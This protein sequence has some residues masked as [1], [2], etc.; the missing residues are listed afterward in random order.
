MNGKLTNDEIAVLQVAMHFPFCGFPVGSNLWPLCEL[1]TAG[2]EV[3]GEVVE[4]LLRDGL[5]TTRPIDIVEG[6][7]SSDHD[8]APDLD[9]EHEVLLT[10]DGLA[11]LSPH[12]EQ[13][14]TKV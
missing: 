11:A 6:E 3:D 2:G 9:F 1:K 5:L 13:G 12:I 4:K 14:E 10:S 7:R 8:Y